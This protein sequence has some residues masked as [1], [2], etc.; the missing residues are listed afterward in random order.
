MVL[1]AAFLRSQENYLKMR[2]V[3]DLAPPYAENWPEMISVTRY[4]DDQGLNA[5]A[6]GS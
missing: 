3:H 2:G 4:V 5:S 6:W 1:P